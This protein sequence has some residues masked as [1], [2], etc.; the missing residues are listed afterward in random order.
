MMK[1]LI[2]LITMFFAE[3]PAVYPDSVAI[4]SRY[5]EPLRFATM[6]ACFDHVDEHLEALK[7]YAKTVY[8]NAVAV[9][10][11]SCVTKSEYSVFK[12]AGV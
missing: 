4:D 9:K 11:I 3:G 8:P 10:T 7:D 12:G 5:G 2:I 6:E 1:E